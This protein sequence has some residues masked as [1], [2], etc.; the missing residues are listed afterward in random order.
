MPRAL[1]T[2]FAAHR[3]RSPAAMP[4]HGVRRPA[5]AA[6]RVHTE[7][8]QVVVECTLALLLRLGLLG[9]LPLVLHQVLQYARL[10]PVAAPGWMF[11][12][13][14]LQPF[15]VILF[16]CIGS[17]IASSGPAEVAYRAGLSLQRNW[18]PEVLAASC[19][20]SDGPSSVPSRIGSANS[21]MAPLDGIA[22]IQILPPCASTIER[23]T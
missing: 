9:C 18:W 1:E 22:S 20:V 10:K 4:L 16:P 17:A 21:N 11:D 3:R 8:L 7:L 19:L 6:G 2:T 14:G 23:Q 13:F 5:A 15:T 12:A